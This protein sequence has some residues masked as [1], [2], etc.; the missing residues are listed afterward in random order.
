MLGC[1]QLGSTLVNFERQFFLL[2]IGYTLNR[3]MVSIFNIA[4][5]SRVFTDVDS[6]VIRMHTL[7]DKF[8]GM[9]VLLFKGDKLFIRKNW[10]FWLFD[11]DEI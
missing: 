5:A 7:E 8:W 1:S 11:T 2:S 6:M 9:C 10:E 4:F 3:S